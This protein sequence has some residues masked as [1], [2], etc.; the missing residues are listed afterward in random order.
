MTLPVPLNLDVLRLLSSEC[1][2]FIKTFETLILWFHWPVPVQRCVPVTQNMAV[3]YT[4]RLG[5]T[6]A[7]YANPFVSVLKY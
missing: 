4:H 3:Q 7:S 6:P 2:H 1:L 5:S